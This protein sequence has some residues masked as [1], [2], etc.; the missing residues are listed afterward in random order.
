MLR[1]ASIAL[2]TTSVIGT[3]NRISDQEWHNFTLHT[4]TFLVKP[5]FEACECWRKTAALDRLLT[6]PRLKS[7]DSAILNNCLAA[8]H[9]ATEV[10]G[11]LAEDV[12]TKHQRHIPMY[13][14]LAPRSHHRSP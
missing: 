2:F 14:V 1:V 4:N 3:M 13:A 10:V 6:H 5:L 7:W 8:I 9:P 12:V 11:F